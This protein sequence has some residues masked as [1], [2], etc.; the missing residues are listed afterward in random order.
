M[1]FLF[2]LSY[3]FKLGGNLKNRVVTKFQIFFGGNYTLKD[4]YRQK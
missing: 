1:V 2:V 4:T 3:I